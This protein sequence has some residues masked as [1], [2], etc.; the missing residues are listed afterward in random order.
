[1]LLAGPEGIAQERVE[2]F[3]RSNLLELEMK[4]RTIIVIAAALSLALAPLAGHSKES[5]SL[6]GEW[7]FRA[8]PGDVG[9]DQ[10]WFHP[11]T[12][13]DRTIKV[14]G[15][16]NAQGVG[17][18]SKVMFASYAGAGWYR[19]SIGLPASWKGERVWLCFERVHRDAEVWVNGEYVGTH[20]GYITGFK[21]D[22]TPYTFKTWQADIVV[23]V[24]SRRR[25]NDDPLYGCMDVMDM[26]GVEWGGI[27]GNVWVEQTKT[28][29]IESVLVRPRMSS[30][31]AEVVV[32][33]GSRI[34]YGSP[35]RPPDFHIEADVL[36]GAGKLVGTNR[37]AMVPGLEPSYV[38]VGIDN[39]KTWSPKS[40]YLYRVNVRLYFEDTE[41]DSVTE[42]FGM[43]EFSTDGSRFVLNGKPIFL[44]GFGD[45]CV[46]PNSIAPPT[47]KDFYKTRFKIAKDYG[48]NYVR[49]HSWVPPKEYFE[50]ADEVGIMVQP[51]FPIAYAQFYN[52]SS[53]ELQ[54]FYQETWLKM[55]KANCNHP[56]IVAW[57][58][59]NEMWGGF[60]LA[61]S[62]YMS[63]REIDP[64][65][66]IIDS[67][68]VLAPRPGERM[69]PTLD[70][71]AVQFDEPAKMGLADRKYD[72]GQWKPDKPVV[73][74]E[75]GNFGAFP[76]IAQEKL[77]GGGI[78]P[79]WLTET[80]LL[81][82]KNGFGGQLAKWRSCSQRLQAAAL[83]V[84]M[85]AARLARGIGGYEQWLL[86]DYWTGSNGVLDMFLRPKALSPA[87]FRKFNAPTVLLMETTRRSYRHG[88]I[89]QV[90]LLVSRYEEAA[91]SNAKLLWKLLDSGKVVRQGQK[92]GLKIRSDGLQL[93][94]SVSLKMP[95][96]GR[97]RKLTLVAQL[98]DSNG[99][100]YN[101]WNLWVFPSRRTAV[102]ANVCIAGCGEIATLYPK[103]RRLEAK[104]APNKCDL[105]ITSDLDRTVVDFL[106][107]GGRVLLVGSEN[108]LPTVP[109][110]YKPYWWLGNTASDSNAGTVVDVSHPALADMPRADW[111]DL[112][113]YPLLNGSKAVLLDELPEPIEPIVRCIDLPTAQRNKAY[114]FEARV[115]SGRLLVAS[116]NFSAALGSNDPCAEF[117]L[118][119]LIRYA[120][121]SKFEPAATLPPASLLPRD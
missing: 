11:G 23:R 100:V 25:P 58:M 95:S 32:D 60:D 36:D 78:K 24:D 87:E 106:A 20:L 53:P 70:F 102:S 7:E 117:L 35:E 99:V 18:E 45:D 1:M 83:K 73:I 65:R 48:F 27:C 96:S 5:V 33:T 22:I 98:A 9:K 110:S 59:S 105:L 79:Y 111:C 28:A 115:G 52:A 120:V 116:A 63:A 57:S 75:M 64:T 47:D 77:F 86:Q 67:D 76:D 112:E 113:W 38:M 119:C 2:K 3:M 15:A 12:P 121:S 109:S 94:T 69:R 71:Y 81:A 103:A 54:K 17:E 6:S 72:L 14:P 50:A 101:S 4:P 31:V 42:R 93:L 19:K 16:W 84:N 108:S 90:K 34:L 13:F 39:P 21:F 80:R 91:S 41:L 66:L 43:R 26:P 56:S 51:E 55:I 88:E 114:L 118:D 74:H 82:D 62:M 37:V 49:C 68:G 8:D 107:A 89:A 46:F 61:Q 30:G 97:A 92:A 10:K 44:R 104:S 85:E 40:P 29:W